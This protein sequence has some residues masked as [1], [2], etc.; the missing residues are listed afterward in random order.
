MKYILEVRETTEEIKHELR[1]CKDYGLSVDE[2]S[3]FA[4]GDNIELHYKKL[5]QPICG[6]GYDEINIKC[7]SISMDVLSSYHVRRN[8][9]DSKVA[10]NGVTITVE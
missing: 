3:G 6:M 5:G 7:T 9:R 10:L 1:N 8:G 2:R 4:I